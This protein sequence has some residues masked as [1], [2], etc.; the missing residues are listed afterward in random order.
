M[1]KESE[2]AHVMEENFMAL[3]KKGYSIKEIAAKYNLSFA[4]GYNHL[5]KIADKYGV[6]RDSLLRS[7]RCGWRRKLEQEARKVGVDI[8]LMEQGFSDL[9]SHLVTL[10]GKIN[11]VL[12]EEENNETDN[13]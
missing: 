6:S 9:S 3:H 13:I 2:R 8:N 10:M 12:R 11:E 1:A 4:T 5:Q 7:P